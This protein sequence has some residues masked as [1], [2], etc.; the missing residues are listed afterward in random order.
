MQILSTNA[1]I[2]HIKYANAIKA[3]Y[4]NTLSI[5]EGET[6]KHPCDFLYIPQC[7]NSVHYVIMLVNPP[8]W[9]EGNEFTV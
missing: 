6:L 9:E 5:K 2:D 8:K 3:R 4:T 7:L 1:N